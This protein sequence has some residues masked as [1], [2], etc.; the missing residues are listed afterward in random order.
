MKRAS[1][2][3]PGVDSFTHPTAG[4]E[5]DRFPLKG[6]EDHAEKK[7]KDYPTSQDTMRRTEK[8]ISFYGRGFDP[9]LPL[10]LINSMPERLGNYNKVGRK[11]SR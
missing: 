9:F 3:P 1:Y 4:A 2:Q 8:V 11:L 7:E 10:N 6:A 5:T